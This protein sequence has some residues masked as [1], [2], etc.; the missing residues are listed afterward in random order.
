MMQTKSEDVE[1]L[2]GEADDIRSLF[3][4]CQLT[5]I[6]HHTKGHLISKELFVSSSLPKNKRK[7]EKIQ[8]MIPQ[9]ELFLKN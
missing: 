5:S 4:L 2:I 3:L 7:N 6:I 1:I 8:P 9:F